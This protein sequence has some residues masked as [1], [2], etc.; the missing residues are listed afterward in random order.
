VGTKLDGEANME[1]VY[2]IQDNWMAV[3]LAG[4]LVLQSISM[5]HQVNTY[6]EE[7]KKINV[8]ISQSLEEQNKL[9]KN[10]VLERDKLQQLYNEK[11]KELEETK[12]NQVKTITE[13]IE[14]NPEQAIQDIANKYGFK[15]VVGGQ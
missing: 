12:R 9:T 6:Q 15:V 8:N 5:N 13:R 14:E 3:I 11:I 7:L 1:V 10:Y 2:W 4:I